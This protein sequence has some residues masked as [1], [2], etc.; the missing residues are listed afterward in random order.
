VSVR[1]YYA[2]SFSN[3]GESIVGVGEI[4]WCVTVAAESEDNALE[5]GLEEARVFNRE[6][7]LPPHRLK[8]GEAELRRLARVRPLKYA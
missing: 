1:G 6:F 5:L 3:D 2:V 7:G 4:S 8:I